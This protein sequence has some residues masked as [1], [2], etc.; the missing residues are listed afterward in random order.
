MIQRSP[1]QTTETRRERSISNPS[2]IY[3][4]LNFSCSVGIS[5]SAP[6]NLIRL[7]VYNRLWVDFLPSRLLVGQRVTLV[8]EWVALGPPLLLLR[9]PVEG[10][11][12]S[13]QCPQYIGNSINGKLYFHWTFLNNQTI[14]APILRGKQRTTKYVQEVVICNQSLS[15]PLLHKYISLNSTFELVLIKGQ[16]K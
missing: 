10:P 8:T 5:R 2:W 12:W 3:R 15:V 6:G 1:E 9:L 14:F 13:V 4:Q 11:A 7:F 16:R